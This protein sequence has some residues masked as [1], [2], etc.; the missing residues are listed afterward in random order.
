MTRR[1]TTATAPADLREYVE[2]DS[3]AL[4]QLERVDWSSLPRHVAVI[5]DGN[6]RWAKQ[7]G[8]PRVDGHRAGITSV[9]EV[10][11]TAA[12]AGLEM[13]TLYAFSVEN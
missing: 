6:G 11:E 2:T 13:L 7:R 1:T 3:A 10:V 9:R 12:R 8:L 4:Q 5:M